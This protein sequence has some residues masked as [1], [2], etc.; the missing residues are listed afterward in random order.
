MKT[1]DLMNNNAEELQFR[2]YA[3]EK[4]KVRVTFSSGRKKWGWIHKWEGRW[5][6]TR[7]NRVGFSLDTAVQVQPIEERKG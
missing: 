1:L 3:E 4:V 2:R 6:L 7:G 5:Y